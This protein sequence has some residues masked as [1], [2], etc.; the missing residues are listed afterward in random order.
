MDVCIERNE[1]GTCY[2]SKEI[3]WIT[4]KRT[5]RFKH[6]KSVPVPIPGLFNSGVDND[7]NVLAPGATDPHWGY[8]GPYPRSTVVEIPTWA[9]NI[10][11]HSSDAMWVRGPYP[12]SLSF[13][14]SNFILS[15]VKI[16]ISLIVCELCYGCYINST[17]FVP[18]ISWQPDGA[19]FTWRNYSVPNSG[20]VQG[21]NSI[22]LYFFNR[23]HSPIYDGYKIR[24]TGTGIKK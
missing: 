16:D 21:M 20:L 18:V 13:D 1:D 19:Y 15:T 10:L 23:W 14:L 12:N 3:P 4:T 11:A 7:H 8:P 5:E 22:T 2:I 24:I 17:L 6:K 9:N